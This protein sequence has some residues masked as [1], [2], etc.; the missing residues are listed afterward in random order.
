MVG[1]IGIKVGM[2]QVFDAEGAL[3][4]TTVIR[5][6]PNYVVAK[7]T[8]EK[9][10]YDAVLLGS[11]VM[12][13]SR[14]R[15]PYA[16]QFPQGLSPA[17][18]L[19][20]IRGFDRECSVGDALG[21]ELFEGVKR[22]DVRGLS[23]GRGFQGVMKR[24]GFAGG[25]KGHGAKFH[26]EPGSTGNAGLV[27]LWK[28]RKMPGRMGNA[29]RTMQNLPILGVDAANGILLVKGCVPGRRKA[30]LCVTTARKGQGSE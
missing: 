24:H 13:K 28:G 14:V 8:V 19:K 6:E 10:G 2:T 21:V 17:L 30:T 16:G 15:K 11:G 25:P 27:G 7:R 12:K 22:V 1:L 18:Q 23:K 4:P 26:R 5:I 3:V 9:N 20:E 29:N